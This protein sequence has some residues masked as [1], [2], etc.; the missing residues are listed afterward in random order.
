MHDLLSVPAA[1]SLIE[2]ARTAFVE[3]LVTRCMAEYGIGRHLR[4]LGSVPDRDHI[5]KS[6]LRLALSLVNFAVGPPIPSLPCI[7]RHASQDFIW[8]C[9]CASPPIWM[10][11]T[12][13]GFLSA[14]WS[15]QYNAGRRSGHRLWDCVLYLSLCRRSSGQRSGGYIIRP[16]AGITIPAF[17]LCEEIFYAGYRSDVKVGVPSY[18]SRVPHCHL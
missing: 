14:I 7:P 5:P 12:I 17:I 13:F 11:R 18:P 1:F 4:I 6:M 16:Y 2:R 9:V 10:T 15:Y 3:L 8:M